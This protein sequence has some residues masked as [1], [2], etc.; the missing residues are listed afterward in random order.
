M[1]NSD[2]PVPSAWDF[3]P[4]HDLLRLPIDGC[5]AKPSRHNQ[6]TVPSFGEQAKGDPHY[7]TH[8]RL[9]ET[10][11][12]RANPKLGDFDSLWELFNGGPAP[13]CVSPTLGPTKT[14]ESEL[15]KV[16][17]LDELPS[18]S[19][20]RPAKNVSFSDFFDIETSVPVSSFNSCIITESKPRALKDTITG[21]DPYSSSSSNTYATCIPAG[22]GG[23]SF[24]ILKRSPGHESSGMSAN[25]KFGTPPTPPVVI[26]RASVGDLTGTPT[27][28]RKLRSRGKDFRKNTRNNPIT[29]EESAGLESDT[30]IV[31]DYSISDRPVPIP[32]ASSRVNKL[33]AKTRPLDTPPSSFDDNDWTL[34]ADTIRG[35][36]SSGGTRVRSILHQSA[37]ERRATLMIRLVGHFPTYANIVYQVGQI[38]DIDSPPIHVFV[39]MSNIMVGFHDAV[40]TSRNIPLSTRIPRVHMSFSNLSL[41]MER[42]RQVA[43]K[44]LVGS[45][46]LPFADE[47][48]TL[49][50]ETNILERVHK[51]KAVTPRRNRKSRKYPGYSS[52]G[53]SS[54]PETVAASGERWVEQGVDEI[55]HLKILESLVDT[56]DPATIVLATGDAAVAEFSGGFMKMVERAL[57]RGWNIELVSFAQGTSYAYRKKE[58][59]IRWGERFKLV[60]LDR[61]LEELFQEEF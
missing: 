5:T 27:A 18:G 55:L 34:N 47:A 7:T 59:R 14:T 22:L 13:A 58:F 26:A 29:S 33:G 38:S 3:T 30:S 54:G 42:G 15:G 28:K 6:S 53:G 9:T 2:P 56:V 44:V 48:E 11:S 16:P 17:S 35:H 25:V 32:F 21:N 20:A 46:H 49:G 61:Y 1:L 36:A 4:V 57:Q 52:Q 23:Q 19:A 40:K 50:Y 31:C 24:T 10:I 41:I 45:D 39:D 51:V 60:E 37:A 12:E 43:K 8:G